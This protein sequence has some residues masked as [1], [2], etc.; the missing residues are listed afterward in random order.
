MFSYHNLS[1]ILNNWLMSWQVIKSL[2]PIF[3]LFYFK[4]FFILFL[5]FTILYRFCQI[6]KWIRHRYTCVPHPEASSLLLPIPSLWVVPVHQP[7]ASSIMHQ[8][9]TGDSFH[10]WYYTCFNAILPNLPTLSLSH[11]VLV[12]ETDWGLVL[13]GGAMLSKSLI[14]FLIK[15]LWLLPPCYLTWGQTV[16]EVYEDNGNLLQ[17]VPSQKLAK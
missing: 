11:R 10:T 8:T 14:Q 6:S 9:W 13:M 17:K 3:I 4:K 7:Q 15:F 12:G 2:W 5:N 16:V 1:L